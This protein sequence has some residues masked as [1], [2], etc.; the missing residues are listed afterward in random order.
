MTFDFDYKGKKVQAIIDNNM[1]FLFHCHKWV[2]QS[3]GK[4]HYLHT[5]INNKTVSLHRFICGLKTDITG[6]HIHH[7]NK[8]GLDNRVDNLL[9]VTN[10]EHAKMHG[11]LGQPEHENAKRNYYARFK[12][13]SFCESSLEGCY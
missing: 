6:L 5:R 7:M 3:D 9:I 13:Q 2:I 12:S 8:N 10:G 1:G 11:K 4:N